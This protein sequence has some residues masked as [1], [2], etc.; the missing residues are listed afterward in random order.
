MQYYFEGNFPAVYI[1]CQAPDEV[2][3]FKEAIEIA[4]NADQ[5]ILIAGTNS[6]WE[7]EGN[8]RAELS[9]PADQDSLIKAIL[10]A[11][12]NTTVVINT[13]SPVEMTWIDNADAV[14]QTWFAGQ[15]FGNALVDIITGEVNP[16]GRLPTTFPKNIADTPAY[17]CYPGKDAQM[18]YDEKLLVGYRWYDRKANDPLFPFGHGLSYTQFQY[19]D[20][21]IKMGGSNEVSCKFM[22]AN[23]GDVIGA[24]VAQCYVAFKNSDN[25]EPIKTLQGFAKETIGAGDKKTVEIRLTQRN[26][27]YWDIEDKCWKIRQGSYEILIGSSAT[28]IHLTET[29]SLEQVQEVLGPLV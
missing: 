6:D 22:I 10:E 23:I 28:R 15:E 3:L 14:I 16:S 5:V 21:E 1:G 17:D 4:G 24:E 13:G 19:S 7:T 2:D 9:L 18:N 11:N 12:K 20:L 27:S 29:I 26:F 8:D 25:A